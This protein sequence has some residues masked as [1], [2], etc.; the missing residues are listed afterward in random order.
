MTKA[1]TSLDQSSMLL[2]SLMMAIQAA[3]S[4]SSP[5]PSM[6]D[7]NVTMMVYERFKWEFKVSHES[8]LFSIQ[9]LKLSVL[10]QT[11]VL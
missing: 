8:I 4:V 11:G 3:D 6:Y 7:M 1:E 9:S 10:I 2:S 5:V